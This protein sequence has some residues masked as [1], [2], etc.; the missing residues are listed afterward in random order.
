MSTA[1]QFS[2]AVQDL[3]VAARSAYLWS[4]LGWQDIK[5]RYRRSTLGPLW[6]TVSSA[7]MIVALGAVYAAIFKMNLHDYF[8]FLAVGLVVWS[9]LSS[10]VTDG[11]QVFIVNE[12]MI[13]QVRLPFFVHVL[14]MVWRN[15][16]IFAHNFI[17]VVLVL[18]YFRIVPTPGQLLA[19]AAGLGLTLVNAAWLGMV[20]GCLCAR[21][22]DIPLIVTSLVQLLFFLTPVIW[23]PGL[24]PGRHRVVD[25]N[26]IYHFIEVVRAPLLG[27]WPAPHSWAA[28]LL[29]TL[30]GWI[31]TTA[32][33][34]RYRRRIAYWL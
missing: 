13:K 30:I 7:V 1:S 17:I 31:F 3:L 33:L 8:P 15:L 27:Q 14:R 5:Q 2:L 26:P 28:V 12:A 4:M 22:R 25:W 20:L 32:W 21:F 29:I 19:F 10:I 24:M 34:T 18:A 11:C 23:H 16:I 6:L 9:L